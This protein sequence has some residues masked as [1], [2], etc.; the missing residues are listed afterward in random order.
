[1]KKWIA[2]C[3][4][5]AFALSLTACSGKN[6]APAEPT[7]APTAEPTPV[8]T[9]EPTPEPTPDPKPGW[10]EWTWQVWLPDFPCEEEDYE[11]TIQDQPPCHIFKFHAYD[12]PAFEAYIAALPGHGYTLEATDEGNWR[13]EDPDGNRIF[14]EYMSDGVL[15]IEVYK[16]F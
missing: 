8:P 13:G 12:A 7:P 9:P 14:I 10:R 4:C 15:L 5:I 11:H 6:A 3:L 2:L 1:M 16:I